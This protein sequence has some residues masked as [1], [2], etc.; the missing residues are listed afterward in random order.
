MEAGLMRLWIEQELAQLREFYPQIEHKVDSGEDWFR[1][2]SYP[3]APGWRIGRTKISVDAPI[4]FK[5]VAAYPTAVH[6]GFAAPVFINF[7]GE[8]PK[9]TDSSI[10]FPFEGR[11]CSTLNG[12]RTV[13]GTD[14]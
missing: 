9:N 13:M 2:P 10:S 4:A 14:K 11:H 7:K 8:P 3:F 1:L 6:Y 5:V 12:H